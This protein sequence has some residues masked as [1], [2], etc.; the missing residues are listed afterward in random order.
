MNDDLK[1]FL[2]YTFLGGVVCL[3]FLFYPAVTFGW[4]ISQAADT[5]FT[6]QTAVTIGV[7]LGSIAIIYI[8]VLWQMA[9]EGGEKAKAQLI[10]IYVVSIIPFINLLKHIYSQ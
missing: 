8:Y 5:L 3:F 2:G 6:H 4:V 1:E 9:K 7:I 10:C